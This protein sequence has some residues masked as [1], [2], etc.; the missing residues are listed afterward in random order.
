MARP[1]RFARRQKL[2]ALIR[3]YVEIPEPWQSEWCRYLCVRLY[4]YLERTFI[5]IIEAYVDGAAAPQVA[6]FAASRLAALN[7]A[8]PDN[9]VKI[10]REFN[11]VWADTLEAFL[12]AGP[13]KAHLG[14]VTANRHQI[15]HG[16]DVGLTISQLQ[17]YK[18]SVEE[19]LD[20]VQRLFS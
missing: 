5:E 4:G 3:A 7:S 9:C 11:G 15:A 19:I 14:S 1:N 12:A 13:V 10:V 2:E 16:N 18:N 8:T 20:E 17:Q 6:A